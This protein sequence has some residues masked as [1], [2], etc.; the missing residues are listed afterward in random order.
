MVHFPAVELLKVHNSPVEREHLEPRS[1]R[2]RLDFR[3]LGFRLRGLQFLAI[4]L[5]AQMTS[6]VH[7]CSE[8]SQVV[9]GHDFCM[10]GTNL[11]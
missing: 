8:L 10:P 6:L 5:R 11:P 1:V 3:G 9:G 7:A 2:V 4:G